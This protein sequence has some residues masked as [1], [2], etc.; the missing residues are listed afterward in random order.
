M[1]T[2]KAFFLLECYIYP[3]TCRSSATFFPIFNL[4]V[5]CSSLP[6]YGS[7]I[8]CGRRTLFF[9]LI[10][11]AEAARKVCIVPSF[12]LPSV[13]N[14]DLFCNFCRSLNIARRLRRSYRNSDTGVH[15]C[16][17]GITGLCD[18]IQHPNFLQIYEKDA[19][20][21]LYGS[22][23]NNFYM[24]IPEGFRFIIS[25][26]YIN[27]MNI[28]GTPGELENITYCLIDKFEMKD[29]D[30]TKFCL[31]FQTEHKKIGFLCINPII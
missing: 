4:F 9:A 29:L 6:R 7:P 18:P 16:G 21:Y 28:I 23:D 26:L 19:T 22:L 24:K 5:S 17:G 14:V 20:A 3:Y 15:R 25:V 27:D 13:R 2:Y 1:S 11:P 30:K 10:D 12:D 8:S 31:D